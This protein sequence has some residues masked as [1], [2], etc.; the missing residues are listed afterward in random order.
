MR[1][2]TFTDIG[3]ICIG[4]FYS[5]MSFSQVLMSRC[6]LKAVLFGSFASPKYFFQVENPSILSLPPAWLLPAHT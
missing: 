4:T 5:L 6:W 2:Q 3:S 1:L